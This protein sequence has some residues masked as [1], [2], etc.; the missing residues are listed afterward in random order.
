LEPSG[1][2][3]AL[4]Q[5]ERGEFYAATRQFDR[6]QN[7]FIGVINNPEV[8]KNLPLDWIKA[9]HDSLAIAVRVKRDP[10]LARNVA[11]AVLTTDNAPVFERQDAVQ[12]KASIDDWHQELPRIPQTETGLYA[13]MVRLM[14]KAH[15]TQKYPA[16]HSGDV[17]Y[18][19]AS[20]V[21]HDLLQM[22]PNGPLAPE[23][24]LMEGICYEVL[25]PVNLEDLHGIYYEA[26]IRR[27]P[28]TPTAELCYRRY[29]QSTFF[30]YT[31]SAG[32]EIP[33]DVREKM[34]E[35]GGLAVGVNGIKN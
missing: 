29:E 25:S 4:S 28:H 20:S 26:C 13:E 31:G 14:S 18:L 15:D 5:V 35:L 12:W 23:A 1:K 33:A 24:L 6:A 17:Y 9:V 7:E 27:A 19:R 34:L 8:A 30:D 32:M 10:D 11:T 2:G 3:G 22:A 21:A 16:D